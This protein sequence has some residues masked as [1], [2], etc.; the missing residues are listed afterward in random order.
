MLPFQ[1]KIKISGAVKSHTKLLELEI[2]KGFDFGK[3]SQ[4]IFFPE[5]NFG[6]LNSSLCTLERIF[7]ILVPGGSRFPT[8]ILLIMNQDLLSKITFRRLKSSKKSK[9]KK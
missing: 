7:L 1:S 4:E 3:I 5:M 2:I 9:V 8:V 6:Y